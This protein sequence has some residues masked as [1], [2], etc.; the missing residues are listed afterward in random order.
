P[1]LLDFLAAKLRDDPGQSLKSLHRLIVTSAAW[2]QSSAENAAASAVDAG[3]TLCWRAN[4]RRL[5]AEELRDAVLSV[6]GKLGR[7]MGGPSFQD[8]VIEKPEHSPHY[9]Y[10]LHDPDDPKAQRRSIYRMIVR[11][12][13][14]PFLTTLDCADPSQMVAKRDETT[15]APQALALMNNPFMTA[16]AGHFAARVKDAPSPTAAAFEIATGRAP[17]PEEAGALAEYGKR[18]GLA[19]ACRVILNLSEFAYV[20]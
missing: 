11:S 12:R 8:F 10:E 1:E 9:E 19:N 7:E 3:N 17:R 14:Q 2:R 5:S 6:S 15:T 13:T 20:D 18:H 4:R 16:M